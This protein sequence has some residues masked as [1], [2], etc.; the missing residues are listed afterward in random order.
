MAACV[1]IH[2]FPYSFHFSVRPSGGQLL[3]DIANLWVHVLT[4]AT[5][6]AYGACFIIYL[7]DYIMI[8]EYFYQSYIPLNHQN[9]TKTSQTVNFDRQA[10]AP[11][12]AL[13]NP[14]RTAAC[15]CQHLFMFSHVFPTPFCTCISLCFWDI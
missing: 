14:H 11:W 2:I 10:H 5:R 3:L 9:Q 1:C 15:F 4:F 7:H 6:R 13:C 8:Y 12:N